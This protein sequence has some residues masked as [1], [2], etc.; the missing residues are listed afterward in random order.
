MPLNYG[1]G[2]E[3]AFQR[4]YDEFQRAQKGRS[5]NRSIIH[6]LSH[7]LLSF[8]RILTGTGSNFEE[9]SINFSL[10]DVTETE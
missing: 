8:L 9:F 10:A 7:S 4:L 2:N 6:S 3:Y 1:E 5:L